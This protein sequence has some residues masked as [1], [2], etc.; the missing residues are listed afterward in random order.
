MPNESQ[1]KQKIIKAQSGHAI[2]G[3]DILGFFSVH[4]ETRELQAKLLQS[5]LHSSKGS[6]IENPVCIIGPGEGYEQLT[7]A[8]LAGID[9][10]KKIGTNKNQT[11]VTVIEMNPK[12][13]DN[14]INNFQGKLSLMTAHNPNGNVYMQSFIETDFPKEAILIQAGFVWNDLTEKDKKYLIKKSLRCLKKGGALVVADGFFTYPNQGLRNLQRNSEKR[15]NI[16]MELNAYYARIINDI[17]KA[18]TEGHIPNNIDLQPTIAAVKT[19]HADALEGRDGRESFDSSESMQIKIKNACKG[20]AAKFAVHF[21]PVSDYGIN[22]NFGAVF[23]LIK[24]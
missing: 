8:K 10:L 14:L 6:L 23:V 16:E 22:G 9:L 1:R 7:I 24:R 12:R 18:Q 17:Q 11:P 3:H 21:Y 15:I 13:V 20:E 5:A 19:A 4:K 2:G